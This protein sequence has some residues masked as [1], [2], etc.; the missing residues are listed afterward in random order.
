MRT[1]FPL[2]LVRSFPGGLF[3][4]GSDSETA[5]G[6]GGLLGFVW[7][8][9]QIDFGKFGRWPRT[10]R[11]EGE[12]DNVSIRSKPSAW[13]CSLAWCVVHGLRPPRTVRNLVR[14]S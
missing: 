7:T 9:Y 10:N 11:T 14:A 6:T 8:Q 3:L 12:G 1:C 13:S 4:D 2:T 5:A